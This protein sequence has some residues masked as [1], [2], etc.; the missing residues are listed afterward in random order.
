MPTYNSPLV[1]LATILLAPATAN[2]WHRHISL[3]A[4]DLLLHMLLLL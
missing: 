1:V 3:L 4:P 2:S